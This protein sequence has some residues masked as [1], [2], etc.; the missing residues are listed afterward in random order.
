MG[1]P[2]V[3]DACWKFHREEIQPKLRGSCI[4]ISR[5]DWNILFCDS[6]VWILH[7]LDT[8]VVDG[9]QLSLTSILT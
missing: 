6:V 7:K 3:E 1:I 2:W 5:K 8:T 9:S 4:V